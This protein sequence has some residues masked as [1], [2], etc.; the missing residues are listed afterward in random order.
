MLRFSRPYSTMTEV[1]QPSFPKARSLARL[2]DEARFVLEDQGRPDATV[3]LEFS[4][5]ARMRRLKKRYLGKDQ[6]VVDVLAFPETDGFPHPDD[7]HRI[8]EILINWDAFKDDYPHMRFLMVHGVLHL[9]GYTHDGKDDTILMERLERTLCRR[10][11]SLESTSDRTR[12]SS[13]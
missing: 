9:L 12:S 3:S 13:S 4:T 8:G 1:R 2:Q 11:A 6:E 7:P 5:M 10:I